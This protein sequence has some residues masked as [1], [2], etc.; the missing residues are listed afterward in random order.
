MVY[1]KLTPEAWTLSGL[2]KIIAPST[3]TNISNTRYVPYSDFSNSLI[4]Q[5]WRPS[6]PSIPS[7]ACSAETASS[8]ISK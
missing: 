2:D 3:V 4:T 6:R 8:A 7:I 5:N 1:I